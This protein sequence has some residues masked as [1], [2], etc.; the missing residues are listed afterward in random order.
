MTVP[1]YVIIFNFSLPFSIAL[2]GAAKWRP[3]TKGRLQTI[4]T[5]RWRPKRLRSLREFL[6]K[7]VKLAYRLIVPNVNSAWTWFDMVG[8][9]NC[10]NLVNCGN[11]CSLCYPWTYVALFVALMG[12]MPRP[13][14]GWLSKFPIFKCCALYRHCSEV[15]QSV[16]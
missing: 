10:E 14:W 13:T 3:K 1:S 7:S 11:V 9:E 15:K 16:I 12:G 2:A 4:F 5:P 8:L 6:A